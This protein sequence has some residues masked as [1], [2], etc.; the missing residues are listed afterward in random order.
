MEVTD[1]YPCPKCGF[2]PRRVTGMEYALPLGTI[3]MGKYLTGRVLGQG[4]FGITY[5]GWD[6]AMERKVAIKEYYP[7]GQVSRNPGTR[8]L[9]WYTSEQSRRARQNGTEIFLKEA[10]KMSKVDSV[11]NVVRVRDL[12]QENETAYIV[13]D[14]VEGETLKARLQKTGPMPWSRAKDIFLPAI[15]AMEQVHKA[16]LVHRDIS[17][18]NLMLTPDGKVMILDLGAAKDLSVNNGASSMQ[19]AKGGFSPLEQYTQRGGSGPWTDVYAMAAT[20]YYTLTGTVPPTAVD[21]VASDPM[22]WDMKGL[23]ASVVKALQSAMAVMP[24]GRTRSMEELEKALYGQS[25]PETAKK[26]TNCKEPPSGRHSSAPLRGEDVTTSITLSF[27]EAALGC[28]RTIAVETLEHCPACK[29]SGMDSGGT[30]SSCPTCKGKGRVRRLQKIN[31]KIPAGVDDGQQIRCREMGS[32][33]LF[34]GTKGD[35]LVTVHVSSHPVFRRDGSDVCSEIHVSEKQADQGSPVIVPILDGTTTLVLP[36]GVR[37]GHVIT[38][39]GKGIPA[40]TNPG[41]RGKHRFTVIVDRPSAAQPP[42]PAGS[43]RTDLK[44]PELYKAVFGAL[45]GSLVGVLIQFVLVNIE[46][47]SS[48][49]GIITYLCAN[50]G[51]LWLARGDEKVLRYRI[52]SCIIVTLLMIGVG[53]VLAYSYLVM[54]AYGDRG[55][56]ISLSSAADLLFHSQKLTSVRDSLTEHIALSYCF[57]GL[58][59]GIGRLSQKRKNKQKK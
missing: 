38:L 9:T 56:V 10:R 17:P 8:T 41:V 3:L 30:H 11:S 49:A 45:L 36:K 52:V 37:S 28:E 39:D 32:V 53:S 29:G 19:V 4:G 44:N 5:I 7:S 31:V 54:Q 18:D 20:I 23:P 57:W 6:L 42:A 12:F 46:L 59:A 22:N 15:Q 25:A 2:D 33:G 48:G 35:L 14:F 16:G 24:D 51:F 27:E 34:S 40:M 21:R 50:A 1:G 58:G 43:D 13:M 47:V 55:T 26:E